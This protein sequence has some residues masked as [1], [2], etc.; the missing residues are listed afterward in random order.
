VEKARQDG[1]NEDNSAP[2]K[3]RAD[4]A[5]GK[6][7]RDRVLPL[8]SGHPKGRDEQRSGPPIHNVPSDSAGNSNGKPKSEFAIAD[9][10]DGKPLHKRPRS[11]GVPGDEYGN[12]HIDQSTSTGMKRRVLSS[13]IEGAYYGKGKIS[14]RPP[15]NRQ[16]KTKG[17]VKRVYDLYR[18][19]MKRRN[20]SKIKHDKKKYY[21][22]NKRRILMYQKARRKSPIRFKRYEGGGYHSPKQKNKDMRKKGHLMYEN[23]K[24]QAVQN[25]MSSM[26]REVVFP[27]EVIS[28]E[29]RV[30]ISY[31]QGKKEIQR[32]IGGYKE[33]DSLVALQILL[34]C[35]RGAHWA[36]WT[37]HWQVEGESQYG[38]HQLLER[39]YNGLVKE[40]DTLAEKIVGGYGSD[41]VAP[42]DQA[43]LMANSL[44]PL[45][46]MRAEANPILRA[47]VVEEAL[48]KIFKRIYDFLKAQNSLS[49][50]MDDFIMSIANEHETN[51]YLLR[52]RLRG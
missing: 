34:A 23:L 6:P 28:P 1:L 16:R 43:Q 3:S 24:K 25:V 29:E 33:M 19:K 37:S 40:I 15:K 10:P 12:P 7:Q 42:V 36:H 41:S 46:E 39:I 8:P 18:K 52:Q 30:A 49:L 44:L 45:V 2:A 26:Y 22:R 17:R 9:H 14:I 50:G 31:L 48:Q 38:D 27:V 21:R 13:E 5:D 20:R 32:K 4:Y 35:L 47:L 51:I 11:S